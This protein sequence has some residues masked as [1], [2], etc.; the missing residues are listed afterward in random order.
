MY[1]KSWTI[2]SLQE[3]GEIRGENDDFAAAVCPIWQPTLME[4]SLLPYLWK[5]V[6]MFK[7]KNLKVHCKLHTTSSLT[8]GEISTTAL[9]A[10]YK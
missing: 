1:L 8:N 10:N 2:P 6:A 4:F 3:G 5:T 7:S 9:L